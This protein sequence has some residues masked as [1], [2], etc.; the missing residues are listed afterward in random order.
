[1][2]ETPAL[3]KQLIG[4]Q[5]R[6]GRGKAHQSTNPAHPTEIVAQGA[7]ATD[8]D[9]AE[10]VAQA[11]SAGDKWRRTPHHE[12]GA[13]LRRAAVALADR[14][15]VLGVELTREEG[16]SLAEGIGEVRRAAQILDFYGSEADREVG[17]IYASPRKGESILVNRHPI[18]VVGVIT[19]FNFPMAIP[20]WKIAPALT[21][22]NTVV[23]KPASV[24]PLLAQR[25]AE[26]LV[27][28]GLPPGVL[29]LV[30]GPGH[31]G[32]SIVDHPAVDAV[33]FTGSTSIG[34]SLIASCGQMAKP[35]QAEMGGKNASIVLADADLDVAVVDVLAGAFRAAGQR[36][37]ATSRLIVHAA[38]ADEFLAA[39]VARVDAMTIGDPLDPTNDL[40]PVVTSA[41]R[42]EI[43]DAVASAGPEVSRLTSGAPP[44]GL[45][46]GHY[47]S[48]SVIELRGTD[49][50][51]WR[52]ELFGPVLSVM[53]C[54]TVDD[55]FRLANDSEFG[56]SCSLY[57]NNMADTLRAM[58]ELKVGI[59]HVNSE[60]GGA[61]PH[62]PFGGTKASSYGPKEQG[63]AAREFFTTLRTTYLRAD[64]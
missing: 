5:W 53:R 41:A 59:L 13:I 23:W 17:A 36:C 31:V 7:N 56:L 19:P 24:V 30:V 2:T 4:S 46:N 48:P 33:T 29:N 25:L 18:G 43:F 11:S 34:R 54:N 55:A 57:T 14:A 49:H 39:L 1:M 3:L 26:A 20:A 42:D 63:R 62:V 40:G 28:A 27:D 21:Y 45:D 9:A 22:G 37:T 6:D 32:Q 47:L 58:D 52:D 51:L 60:T 10:A 50:P 16:K 12:R 38:V 35:I 61:D 8:A 64:R 15:D 44:A